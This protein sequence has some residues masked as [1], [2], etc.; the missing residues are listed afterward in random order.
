MLSELLAGADP[1]EAFTAG[2]AAACASCLMQYAAEFDLA[3]AVRIR[4]EMRIGTAGAG[5]P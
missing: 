1:P 2:V 5:T 4:G 3:E